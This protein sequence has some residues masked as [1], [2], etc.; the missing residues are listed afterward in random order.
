MQGNA[1]HRSWSVPIKKMLEI[2]FRE[3]VVND[4]GYVNAIVRRAFYPCSGGLMTVNV[5]MR[6]LDKSSEEKHQWR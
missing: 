5:G 3:K 4:S 6:R 1:S 2:L